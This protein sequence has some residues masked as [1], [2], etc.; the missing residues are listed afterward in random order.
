MLL[1]ACAVEM[2]QSLAAAQLTCNGFA[3]HRLQDQQH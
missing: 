2:L 1:Q 3:E